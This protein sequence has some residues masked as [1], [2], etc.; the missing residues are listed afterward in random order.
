MWW[1]LV[2]IT[3]GGRHARWVMV[4]PAQKAP[5]QVGDRAEQSSHKSKPI[6]PRLASGRCRMEF[7]GVSGWRQVRIEQR[8][9]WTAQGRCVERDERLL[10]EVCEPLS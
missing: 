2:R 7:N 6:P 1:V 8:L 5:A 10:G 4:K 9:E 3:D